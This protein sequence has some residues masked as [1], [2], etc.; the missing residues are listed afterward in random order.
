MTKETLG[1]P[2]TSNKTVLKWVDE[3]VKLCKPDQVYW[4]DG[5]KAER[6][7]LLAEAVE[8]GVLIKLNPKKL[9]GCYYHR[10]NPNDVARV[11]QATFICTENQDEAGP[12][13]NWMAP[14]DMYAKLRGLAAGSMRGRTL[15][16]VP[17][18]MGPP[19]SPLTKVGIELT[20]SIYVV[21]SMGVMTRMGT[22]AF[23]QLGE[24]DGFNRGLHCMLDVHPDRRY[25]AHFPQDNTVIS[26]GSNYGGN[27]LLGKK[28]LALRIGSYLGRQEGWLA[29][30]MLILGV[31]APNGEK[32]YIAAA[33]PSACGKTN[34]AMMIPPPAFKGWKIWTIGDDIAWMKPGPDGRLYAINP[35]AG[36][37]GVVPGTNSKSNPNAMQ[38][39]SHDTIYTNVA[40]TPDLDVWWEGK[41]GPAP[42]ECLDWRGNKWTPES[43]EK[44]AH[45]NSRFTAPM[46]NNPMLAPEAND[47]HGV[48]I[49]AIIFG[50]RRS[51]TIPLVFQSFNWVHGVYLGATMGSEMTA[52]AVGGAGQVRRDPMAMLPFCGYN[53]GDYFRHWINMRK[54][55]KYPPRIFH[56]NWF[57]KNA[58]G[59]F[60]W[61]GF[62]ENMRVIKWIVDRCHGRADA[63]E[64]PIGWVP[65]PKSFDLNGLPGFTVEQFE[66]LQAINEEEWR[67]EVLMQDELFM[68][69]HSRLP[70]ELIFQRELLLART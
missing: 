46:T 52:A 67:R 48:P 26:V 68:K 34:L 47:P 32:T 28:C 29:E 54:H 70:K 24:G 63:D 55:I 42:K 4:C 35:E 10:S 37:F 9:P 30:H 60:L 43:K 40:L 20:D 38:L 51:D 41:D 61:P 18:L 2:N 8:K 12:T 17:Y 27:V 66:Q 39:I 14:K 6:K 45:P 23:E 5:S 58:Q 11:E 15:Y 64:T 49:S 16:V 65:N 57:R 31:E 7:A 3:I 13:N 19:G 1:R 50:G 59:H 22:L 62:G 36:Y 53:M 56:V 21:L 33:F 25:I 44:A 69:L